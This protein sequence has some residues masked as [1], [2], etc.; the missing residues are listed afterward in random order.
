[1]KQERL[2]ALADGIFAIVMTL[3]VLELRVPEIE[4]PSNRELLNVLRDAWP[5]FFAWVLSFALTY[6]LW[7]AHNVLMSS[8]AKAINPTLVTINLAFFLSVSIIPFSSLLLGRYHESQVAIGFYVLN[9][10]AIGAIVWLM[11]EYIARTPSL[12]ADNHGWTRRDHRNAYIRSLGPPLIGIIAFIVSFSSPA[13]AYAMLVVMGIS[14][15]FSR[16]FDPIFAL[17]DKLKIHH[18]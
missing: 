2:H 18:E 6:T 15:V 14:N 11:R 3:L 9:Q 10:V 12:S 1:V 5:A 4:H 8:F 7:R 16:S 17:L 13:V